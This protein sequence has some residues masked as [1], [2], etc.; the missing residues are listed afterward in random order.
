MSFPTKIYIDTNAFITLYLKR[1]FHE[2]FE[3]FLKGSDDLDTEL[4]TSD[5]TLTEIVKVLKREYSIDSQK[6]GDYI[7]KIKR[8][9]RIG[10]TKFEF[11]DI[12]PDKSYDFNEFFYHLQEIMLKYKISLH[13]A[14]HN[15][16]MKNHE[17]KHIL[18]SDSD[19]DGLKGIIVLDPSKYPI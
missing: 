4:F 6:I 13:D 8:E 9:R 11:I 18:T 12:S 19:F 15:L 14:I 7:Q 5:W 2:N 10:G 17:I 16:V 3:K 1:E